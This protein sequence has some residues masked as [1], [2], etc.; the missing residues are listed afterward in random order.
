[1]STE[2]SNLS[3]IKSLNAKLERDC[4]ENITDAPFSVIYNS[5]LCARGGVYDSVDTGESIRTSSDG[6]HSVRKIVD[7]TV[8]SIFL[9]DCTAP[10]DIISHHYKALSLLIHPD[11]CS[12]KRAK[13]AFEQVR[14]AMT[15]LK[16]E[17]KRK[18]VHDLIEQ[19]QKQG[20]RDCQVSRTTSTTPTLLSKEE[21][22]KQLQSYQEKAIMKV[23]ATIEQ[24]RRDV[25]QQK[26]AQEKRERDQEEE[27]NKVKEEMEFHKRWREGNRVD[28][29][30]GSWRDFQGGD[31]GKKKKSCWK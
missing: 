6:Y 25:E 24:K 5:L 17:D 7:K 29:R 10:L 8:Y 20:T 2:S 18:H 13:E 15:L 23:F 9:E 19:G 30:V 31:G 26:H 21:E 22:E 1:M 14:I 16:V 27:K 11:K 3:G 28:Q 4:P 12:E